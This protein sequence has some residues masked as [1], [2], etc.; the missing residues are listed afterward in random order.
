MQVFDL[1]RR[2]GNGRGVG[3]SVFFGVVTAVGIL[4]LAF[5]S[6]KEDQ[7]QADEENVSQDDEQ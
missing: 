7:N 5:A 2:A 1:D 4:R 6:G 3:R